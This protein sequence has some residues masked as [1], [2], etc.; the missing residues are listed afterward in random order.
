MPEF[1]YPYERAAMHGE[2]MPDGL[3]MA[4]QLAFLCLRQLYSQKQ[5]GVIDRETGSREKA[6]L[7]YQRDLWEKK[8]AIREKAV[9]RSVEMIR[10]V[11]HAASAYAKERTLENGDKMYRA[12]YRM[13]VMK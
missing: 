6:K 3:D 11:E 9:Q 8:F 1:A 2:E 13:V 12:L 5:N 7:I 4:D 10:D